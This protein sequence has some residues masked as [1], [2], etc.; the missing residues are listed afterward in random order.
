MAAR[1]ITRSSRRSDYTPRSAGHF[2]TPSQCARTLRVMRLR[3]VCLA[4]LLTGSAVLAQ[5]A[6]A[7]V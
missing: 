4:L 5:D 1:V 7:P 6:T 3:A 2:A